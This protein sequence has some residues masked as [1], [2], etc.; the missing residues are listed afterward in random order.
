MDIMIIYWPLLFYFRSLGDFGQSGYMLNFT[1]VKC[2]WGTLGSGT[3]CAGR[4][5]TD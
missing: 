5:N 3:F 1:F 2:S 4:E